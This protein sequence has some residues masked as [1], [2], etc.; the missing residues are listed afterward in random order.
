GRL[1]AG[2]GSLDQR[3]AATWPRYLPWALTVFALAIT[4]ALL[5]MLAPWRKT[6][7]SAEVQLVAELGADASLVTGQGAAAVLSP[8]GQTLVF[9]A[10]KAGAA[11]GD[12]YIRR[13]DQLQATPLAGTHGAQ[14]PFFSP[15]GEWIAFFADAKLKK[16][17]ARGGAVVTLCETRNGFGG[18]WAENHTIAFSSSPG[19]LLRVSSAAGTPEPL[20][21]LNEG[22]LSHRW[23]QLLPGGRAVLYTAITGPD[24]DEANLVVESLPSRAR[25]VVQRGGHYGRYLASGH[26]VYVHN[27]TLFVVPL[28]LN[29][30]EVGGPAAPVLEVMTT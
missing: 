27:G 19:P 28:D 12:L 14:N 4:G 3:P 5:L 24:A 16:V 30:L 6:P 2:R 26:L 20:T 15:D 22:E 17:S 23:P 10:R 7:A 29:R 25:K 21:T 1:E 9:V 13:L 11:A 8:D 18:S